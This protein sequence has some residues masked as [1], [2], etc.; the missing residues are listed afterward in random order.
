MEKKVLRRSV[1]IRTIAVGAAIASWLANDVAASA[2]P[3]APDA[4][5]K[6]EAPARAAPRGGKPLLSTLV[7]VLPSCSHAGQV[8]ELDLSTGTSGSLPSTNAAG[9][10]DPKWDVAA[11][12]AGSGLTTFPSDTYSINKVWAWAPPTPPATWIH[13]WSGTNANWSAPSGSYAYQVRFQIADPIGWFS[14]MGIAG[15]CRSDDAGQ[16]S[17]NSAGGAQQCAGFPANT[18]ASFSFPT[19]LG[20]LLSGL[21]TFEAQVQNVGGGPTGLMIAARLRATC[22][23]PPGALT[24]TKNIVN[25][26]GVPTLGTG[27]FPV[28][29]QCTDPNGA[30]TNTTVQ[31][32]NTTL[33]GQV[34]NIPAG[35]QC[36]ISEQTPAD[37][38]P[39]C[40]WSTTYPQGQDAPIG[41]AGSATLSVQN[42]IR[43]DEGLMIWKEYKYNLPLPPP[44]NTSNPHYP[45]GA[46]FNFAISC[47]PGGTYAATMTSPARYTFVSAPAGASCTVAETAPATTYPNANNSSQPCYWAQGPFTYVPSGPITIQPAP[48]LNRVEISHNEFVC[49]P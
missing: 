43:C 29:V 24:V 3:R 36:H 10:I 27:T 48:A 37:P 2:A 31:L 15:E 47:A 6:P 12:P 1:R 34:S 23:P 8:V 46:V 25:N 11:T 7:P 19:I 9:T 26:T 28:L 13:P 49:P 17:V 44:W 4:P 35:S 21:N 32:S 5:S 18:N 42:E 45:T 14:A 22:N 39:F 33:S 20:T 38:V 30:V 16:M 40:Y 41:I